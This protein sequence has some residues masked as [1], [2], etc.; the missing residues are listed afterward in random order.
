MIHLSTATENL[1]SGINK[2]KSKSYFRYNEN[3][4]RTEN[5]DSNKMISQD[6]YSC[7]TYQFKYPK[8]KI[9]PKPHAKIFYR[10]NRS[11]QNI[12]VVTLYQKHALQIISTHQVKK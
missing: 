6:S 1:S 10:K 4:N 11:I 5:C 8:T 3:K 7:K 2:N 12:V 9:P